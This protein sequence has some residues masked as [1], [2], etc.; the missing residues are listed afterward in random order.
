MTKS[1]NR[2]LPISF[3]TFKVKSPLM[4]HTQLRLVTSSQWLVTR[5]ANEKKNFLFFIGSFKKKHDL[6]NPLK[7]VFFK[8]MFFFSNTCFF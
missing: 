6:K 8:N 3:W 5:D 1:A 2:T 4:L 7:T